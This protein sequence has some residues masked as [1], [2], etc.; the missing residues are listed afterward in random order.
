MRKYNFEITKNNDETRF[1]DSSTRAL[2]YVRYLIRSLNTRGIVI[3]K[4]GGT[5]K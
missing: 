3:K 2:G 1:F 4:K 5:R